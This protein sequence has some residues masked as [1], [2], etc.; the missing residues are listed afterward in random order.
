MANLSFPSSTV[1][2]QRIPKTKFYENL[3]IGNNIKRLFIDQIDTIVWQ[4]KLSP[5]TLSVGPGNAV[6]EIEI[7][8]IQLNQPEISF[9]ILQII[10]EGIPYHIL[11][12]LKYAGKIAVAI[13]YKEINKKSNS[14]NLI[15]HFIT[16]P[17]EEAGFTLE[18]SG[19]DMDAIYG[20]IIKQI[21]GI[22]SEWPG[23]YTLREQVDRIIYNEKLDK[24]IAALR[25]KM[26]AETQFN[27]QVELHEEIKRLMMERGK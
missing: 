23:G 26:K 19:L 22:D 7:F 3:A 20:N 16:E 13:G 12:L 21:A 14:V 5:A 8:V 24:D 9:K 10:D 27:R 6:E 4:N 11:F 18:L 2:N 15:K 25:R 1:F 17:K